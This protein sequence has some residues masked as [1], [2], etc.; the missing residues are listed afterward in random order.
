MKNP[1]Q[2][3]NECQ[4]HGEPTFT[5]RAKDRAS[6]VALETYRIIIEES[7][8]V[9]P[10]YKEEIR[11]IVNDFHQWQCQNQHVTRLPD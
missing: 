9:N 7:D 10:E 4:K 3:I 5:I 6:I 8:K 11:Q 1:H 2:I